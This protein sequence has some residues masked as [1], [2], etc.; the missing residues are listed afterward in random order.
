MILYKSY[1]NKNRTQ[2]LDVFQLKAERQELK[3]ENAKLIMK[4]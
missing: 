1:D 2:S 4:L 3:I